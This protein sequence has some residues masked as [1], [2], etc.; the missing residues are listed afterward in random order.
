MTIVSE[1]KDAGDGDRYTA[2]GASDE[3]PGSLDGK[4]PI[5][6]RFCTGK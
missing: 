2:S 4:G 3:E 5:T 1:V 6:K